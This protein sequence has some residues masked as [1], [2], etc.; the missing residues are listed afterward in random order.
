MLI[1]VT[2]VSVVMVHGGGAY[3]AAQSVAVSVLGSLTAVTGLVAVVGW[4]LQP[5]RRAQAPETSPGKL[6]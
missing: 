4:Y 3:T 6:N 2:A 5:H 1:G